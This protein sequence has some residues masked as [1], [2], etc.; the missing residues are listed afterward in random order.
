[1]WQ[2]CL[3]NMNWLIGWLTDP[4]IDC[5]FINFNLVQ[6]QNILYITN[7]YYDVWYSAHVCMYVCACMRV[8]VC[9]FQIYYI[10]SFHCMHKKIWFKICLRYY[11]WI[12]TYQGMLCRK[13]YEATVVK[14]V[15]IQGHH[16]KFHQLSKYKLTL[17]WSFCILNLVWHDHWNKRHKWDILLVAHFC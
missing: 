14:I 7:Y 2:S 15:S 11:D 16:H 1:V 3:N 9:T 10:P 6:N 17:L 5:V 8:Q 13:V 4:V 12:D